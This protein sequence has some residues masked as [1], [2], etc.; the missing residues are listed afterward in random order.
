MVPRGTLIAFTR[1]L[2]SDGGFCGAE[3]RRVDVKNG[4]NILLA[5][6]NPAGVDP[7]ML[8]SPSGAHIVVTG[9]RPGIWIM[10]PDGTHPRALTRNFADGNLSWS[11]DGRKISFTRWD[12]DFGGAKDAIYVMNADGSGLRKIALGR[13]PSWQPVR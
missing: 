9:G 10:R 6:L 4:Q 3:M 5:R 12:Q 7:V 8:W 1:L 11:S 2:C 13:R